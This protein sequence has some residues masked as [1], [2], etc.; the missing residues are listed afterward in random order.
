MKRICRI[1]VLCCLPLSL[2]LLAD[3]STQSNISL[4]MDDAIQISGLDDLNF[5][6]WTSGR[7]MQRTDR[8]CVYRRGSGSYQMTIS[9][10]AALGAVDV[11]SGATSFYVESSNADTIPYRVR[12][13]DTRNGA[14]TH[15]N[16]AINT[17][18]TGLTG[19]PASSN[20]NGGENARVRVVLTRNNLRQAKPGSYAGTLYLTVAPE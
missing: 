14:F 9:A 19:D 15:R 10:G 7:A 2:N 11:A 13:S 5:N 17:P 8:F 4:Q 12:F 16:V 3:S 18:I 1:V 20:C 6:T